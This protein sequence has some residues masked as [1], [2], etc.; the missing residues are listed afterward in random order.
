MVVTVKS[1]SDHQ[2]A[3]DWQEKRER[4]DDRDYLECELPLSRI[5]GKAVETAAGPSSASRG[6]GP[7]YPLTSFP[8]LMVVTD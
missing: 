7:A 6:L 3:S 1:T 8:F 4:K 5:T 2:K